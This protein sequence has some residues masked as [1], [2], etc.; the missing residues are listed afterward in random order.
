MAAGTPQGS[1]LSPL[2]YIILVNDVPNKVTDTGSISQFADDIALWSQAYT[3]QE[4]TRR[5]QNCLNMPEGWCRRWRIMLNASKSYFLLVHKLPEKKPDNL[6]ILLFDDVVR[7]CHNAKFLGLEIDERLTF[8]G[9]LD[10]KVKKAK[11]RMNL[12]RML[13]R[14]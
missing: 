7:P 11:V 5:L 12:F 9:H 1:S 3:F 13:S 6:G 4:A 10:E 14:L 2:L 8:S